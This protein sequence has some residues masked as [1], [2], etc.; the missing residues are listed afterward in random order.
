M[1]TFFAL[2]FAMALPTARS[3]ATERLPRAPREGVGATIGVVHDDDVNLA[4][5]TPTVVPHRWVRALFGIFSLILA[6]S[7][8]ASMG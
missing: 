8:P 1:G 3:R 7:V 2:V 6:F 4:R 5:S